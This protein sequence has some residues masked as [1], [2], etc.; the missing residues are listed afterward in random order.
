[1]IVRL[2]G[3]SQYRVD[4]SLLERLNEVDDRAIAAIEADDESTLDQALDEL[5]ELVRS[6][7]EQLADADL[8]ASDVIV[9]PSDLTLAEAKRFMTDEGFI[10][11]LP[12][13]N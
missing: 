7:G 5:F 1:M 13:P 8:S 11:D 6:E 4:D 2:M 3:E 12:L 10:P 9:P